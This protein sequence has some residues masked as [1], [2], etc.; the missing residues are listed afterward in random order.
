MEWIKQILEG[1]A[2]ADD[3]IAKINAELPKH[4]IPKDKYNAKAD[5]VKSL[6]GQIKERDT[7]LEEFKAQVKDSAELTAQIDKLQA[8][9]VAQK[10]QFEKQV[11]DGKKAGILEKQLRSAGIKDNYIELAKN[12]FN[13]DEFNMNEAGELVGLTEQLGKFKEGYADM[14]GEVKKVGQTPAPTGNKVQ[15]AITQELFDQHRKD[16][17]WIN[18]NW[19]KVSVAMENG[20]LK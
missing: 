14:F 9:N 3:I 18:D 7:K 8:E 19:E 4:F 5:E 10:Q 1:I 20:E 13:L 11:L 2:N 16:P 12:Q 15:D 17:K 6:E